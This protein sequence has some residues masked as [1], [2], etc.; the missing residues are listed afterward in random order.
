MICSRRA[1]LRLGTAG[2]VC[3]WASGAAAA[4]PIWTGPPDVDE[5]ALLGDEIVTVGEYLR[6][7]EAATGRERRSAR[8]RRPAHAEGPATVGAIPSAVVF[9]WY[10]WHEDVHVLCADPRSLALRWQRRIQIS[11]RERENVPYVFPLPR[12]DGVFVLVSHKHGDNLFR[13]S[14]QNGEARDSVSRPMPKARRLWR[15]VP[16]PSSLVGTSGMRTSISSVP[17]RNRFASAGGAASGS[18]RLS[19]RTF[20]MSFR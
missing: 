14:P 2:L 6:I 15:R 12:N 16:M 1:L 20:L 19:A 10:V 17:I 9:G 8:L 7:L 3:G 18:W 13:F 11:E 4:E 5:F